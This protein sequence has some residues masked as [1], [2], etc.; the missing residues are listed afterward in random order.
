MD[1]HSEL[2]DSPPLPQPTTPEAT[3]TAIVHTLELAASH[4]DRALQPLTQEDRTFLFQHGA[5]WT[6]YF[7]PHYSSQSAQTMAQLT[8][9]LH[10]TSLLTEH[11]DYTELITSAQI[12][13]R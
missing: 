3:V 10:V 8:A 1:R 2:P 6:E 7:T 4:R 9:N 5:N 13:A 12:L 11:A